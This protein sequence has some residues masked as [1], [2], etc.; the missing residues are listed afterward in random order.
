M[1]IDAPV[2]Q[3]YNNYCF[4]KKIKLNLSHLGRGVKMAAVKLTDT[5]FFV[6]PIIKKQK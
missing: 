2:L 1:G 3:V 4:Q 5:Y 6:L